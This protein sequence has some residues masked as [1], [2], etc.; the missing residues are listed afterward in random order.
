MTRYFF[1]TADGG[2]HRDPTGTKLPD[3]R[4]AKIEATR[5]LAQMLE[6]NPEDLWVTG[7]RTVTVQD[8]A[9]LTLFVL[10]VDTVTAPAATD[11]REERGAAG[12]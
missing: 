2:E 5:Y 4:A 12:R 6:D 8:E 3:L 7:S 1:H 10:L 11:A 9:G